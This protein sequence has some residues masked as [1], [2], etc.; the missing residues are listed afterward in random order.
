MKNLGVLSKILGSVS[1]L[2]KFTCEIL[3]KIR[4]S[5]KTIAYLFCDDVVSLT[6]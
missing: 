2:R 4:I 6:E 1:Y 3:H 5:V